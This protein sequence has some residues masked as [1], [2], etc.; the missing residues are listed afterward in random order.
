[1]HLRVVN[2]GSG[3]AEWTPTPRLEQGSFELQPGWQRDSGLPGALRPGDQAAGWLRLDRADAQPFR[4]PGPAPPVPHGGDRLRLVFADVA[5]DDYA[6][7][8][9]LRLELVV[10]SER[11][12]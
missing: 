1:V 5:T 7:V 12:S 10:P 9:D 8:A 6:R 11:G 2:G 3:L 4:I